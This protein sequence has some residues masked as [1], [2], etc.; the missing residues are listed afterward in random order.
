MR[1]LE[2]SI[3]TFNLDRVKVS[4]MLLGVARLEI[5]EAQLPTAS[6]HGT[7]AFLPRIR[8]EVSV[9]EALANQV[10]ELLAE[11]S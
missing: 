3:K 5:S 2:A 8:V 7:A 4:L 6:T 11:A 10:V 9:P 1:Q